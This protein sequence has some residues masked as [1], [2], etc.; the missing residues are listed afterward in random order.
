MMT[1]TDTV[2]LVTPLQP[3]TQSAHCVHLQ[4][5]AKSRLRQSR[6]CAQISVRRR[7]YAL[8]TSHASHNRHTPAHMQLLSL[9]AYLAFG[10]AARKEKQAGER[11]DT[12]PHRRHLSESRKTWV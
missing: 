3:T 4:F 11:P 12:A 6:C 1:T 9:G 10:R 5:V 8:E 2:S 7:S